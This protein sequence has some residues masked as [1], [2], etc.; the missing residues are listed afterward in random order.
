MRTMLS[1][2]AIC[3]A[4]LCS[5]S[6]G[7][8]AHQQNSPSL[9]D[10]DGDWLLVWRDEFAGTS[11]N[12]STWTIPVGPGSSFGR[13]ATITK[14]DTFI[15]DGMLI[16]R[17]RQLAP[18]NWTSG[19]A[20]SS[21]R[22]FPSN[23]TGVNWQYGRFCISAKLPGAGPG[24]SQGLWPAHWMMPSNYKQHCG[25]NEIDILEMVN[26]DGSAWGTYWYWGEHD[27]CTGPPVRAGTGSVTIPSYYTEFHEYAVEWTPQSLTYFVDGK[28]YKS[29]T[30]KSMLPVNPH[31]MM[32]NT[33]VG[34]PW[35]GSPNNETVFP[36]YHYIDYVRVSQKKQYEV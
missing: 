22:H 1:V 27:N 11:L 14:E 31:F 4:L 16:L 13:D 18:N 2:A 28:P 6:E 12:L 15:S 19:A 23:N 17:S 25:Y 33:A 8:K 3:L 9:C 10:S 34:G 36:A 35:P 21:P 26:G 5:S 30:N 29:Y 20:I 32:L 24:K 7:Q